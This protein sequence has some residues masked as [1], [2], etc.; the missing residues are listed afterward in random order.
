M[1]ASQLAPAIERLD[2]LELARRIAGGDA[3]AARRLVQGNNQL[4][5]R[6]AW[7]ILRNRDEAEEAVQAGYASA[8]DAIETYAGRSSLSTWLTRI[9]I[10]EALGRLRSARRRRARLD[11]A[12]VADLDHYRETLMQGSR[13]ASPDSS[14]AREQIRT[15][16]EA[17]VASLPE[18]F[19]LVFVLREVEGLSVED[20]AEILGL[21]PAT[22]KTRHL[23]ARRRLQEA[24]APELKTVLAGSFPFAGADCQRM[25]EKVLAAFAAR[26]SPGYN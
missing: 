1:S 11:A 9:V 26:N 17:A 24:L 6:A 16:I 13:T 2:D 14:L 7:S 8:F 4:L 3:K 25:T 23:R 15:L 22:V 19:R 18:G 20:T 21:V 5:Y 12:S 10:N